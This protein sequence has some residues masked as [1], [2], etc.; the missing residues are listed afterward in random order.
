MNRKPYSFPRAHAAVMGHKNHLLWVP[1]VFLLFGKSC[2]LKP[3]TI[4]K[5]DFWDCNS[6]N[7]TSQSC[8]EVLTHSDTEK[9]TWLQCRCRASGKVFLSATFYIYPRKQD[10][11]LIL[12]SRPQAGPS[13]PNPS[14]LW[15]NQNF[16]SWFLWC[17]VSTVGAW[18]PLIQWIS[19][20]ATSFV[21]DGLRLLTALDTLFSSW[22]SALNYYSL[23]IW[24]F[25]IVIRRFS[26]FWGFSNPLY[27]L[28]NHWE[29][30]RA[31]V[32]VI[33]I[34]IYHI[35]KLKLRK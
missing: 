14:L 31:F 5:F 11:E 22:V 4:R 24:V 12:Q 30:Q 16:I 26:N 7:G 13:T 3:E 17:P 29:F 21:L 28:K 32:C 8:M 18:S 35:R 25:F 9:Q 34:N 20:G 15:A 19:R 2:S 1:T 10:P 6:K 33:F 23:I 27:T